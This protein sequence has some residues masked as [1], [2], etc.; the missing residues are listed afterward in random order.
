[1]N[2][3]QKIAPARAEREKIER[4]IAESASPALAGTSL[5]RLIESGGLASWKKF[6]APCLEP[7]IRLLGGSANLS[8]YLIQQGKGWSALFLQQIKLSGKSAAD[9]LAELAPLLKPESSFNDFVLALRRHKRREYLRIGARDLLPE[10]SVEETMREL[11]ALADASLEAA[12]RFCRI[13]T[14]R[15]FGQ[16]RLPIG[17]GKNRFVILGMGK[18]GGE[19][20]NFSSDI[21][22]IYL[23]E[24]EEGESEGGPKGKKAARE[25][26]T[27]LAE[28][29][30]RAL[31]EVTEEGF[32]FR[33]DL[34][35][36]P[37][38]RGG[39]LVQSVASA[40]LYYESWGQCWER[41]ALIKARPAAGDTELG[42]RFLKEIEPFIYRRY[43]DFTTVEELRHM[44]LRIERELLA[45]SQQERNVKLGRGGIRE[46]EFFT[47]ALQL[48]NGGYEPR[49]RERSTAGSLS[50]LARHGYIPARESRTLG[51]AYRFLRNVEHKIQMVQEGHT[52]S[53]PEKEGE[54]LAL[55][56]RLGYGRTNRA[57]DLKLFWRDYRKHTAAV[58]RAFD[59]LFY[60]AQKEIASEGSGAWQEIWNDLDDEERIRESLEGLGFSDPQR[61]YRNLLAVRDGEQFAPPSPRR[62]KALRALGPALM[63]EIVKSGDPDQTLFNLTEF[64]HRV[65]ART[66]ILTLL[67][68]NPKTMRLLIRLFA[69][70]QFL[71]D[72]FIKRP[73]LL[74]SLIRFD[75][76]RLRKPRDE[77]LAEIRSALAVTDDLEANLNAL[78]R[79]RVEEFIRIGLHDLG[80]TLELQEV[81]SQLSSLADAC[82]EGA[83][84]LAAKELE[85]G[86]GPLPRGRFAIL[87]M[88]KL[89]GRELDYNSD[90][91]LIFV[92][93]APDEA[94]SEG[95]P[96]SRLDAHEYY[97]KLGQRL[98]TFLSAPTEEG[99]LYKIDMRL[100][101]SGKSGPLVSSLEAFRDYHRSSSELW[102]R[103][104]LIK[105]RWVAGDRGLGAEAE[106]IAEAF[107]Y[108]SGGL[109]PED[110]GEIH[111][112]RMRMERELAQEDLS[113]FNLKQGL[114]GMVDIEFL[115]QMLQLSFGFRYPK[116]RRRA[117]LAALSA[118]QEL[119]I[120]KER[121]FR[122]LS[123][124]YLFLRQ[125]DHRLRLERGQSLDVLEREADKLQS[126][127][128]AM[129]YKASRRAGRGGEKTAGERLLEDYELRR[130]RIRAC[131]ERYFTSPSK[132]TG[133]A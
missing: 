44:K 80:G 111:H 1:M 76:T 35:L 32:V 115:A 2:E 27:T 118:L 63:A 60:G 43:L 64:S 34:R 117:T 102:E 12:C 57:G 108:R 96:A 42:I 3:L 112:L 8:D 121:E 129:G 97:V 98:I 128:R 88:G 78:R 90:L 99:I 69:N 47:Q 54:E 11:T 50:Q 56:R 23:Y 40:M 74:D 39:P 70:S 110:V 106:R 58:R 5:T 66:G 133:S 37:M 107:A 45:P 75:L 29:L 85:R 83:L 116:L 126:I 130:K 68:E 49:L 25:F 101:P 91:D 132:S 93:G 67:A 113:Q 89:G 13:E 31:S 79:Y 18:L 77:Q 24:E 104:A 94:R 46:I 95:G 26:F 19:E 123:Q 125:L 109:K 72:L 124:G 53:I 105:A 122:L 55:A 22:L 7:L 86:Y 30:T 62:L 33:T 21:D 48:V 73:E 15:D 65:G 17:G 28:R 14:E 52:H 16:L 100:R 87:G 10:I 82:L 127:A 61:A 6:P 36:R 20:L 59:G 41:A 81:L 84:R 131:Y 71:T 4:L 92:Y 103:Q 119:K 120:L 9:H 51:D 38:G 114:G